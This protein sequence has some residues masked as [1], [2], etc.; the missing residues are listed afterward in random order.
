[1]EQALREEMVTAA[2]AHAQE[3]KEAVA[4]TLGWQQ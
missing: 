4:G 3:L 2:A 1:M